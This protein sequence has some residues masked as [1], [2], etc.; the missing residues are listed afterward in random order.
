MLAEALIGPEWEQ[1]KGSLSQELW[2]ALTHQTWVA[3]AAPA[4]LL[5]PM[6]V[7]LSTSQ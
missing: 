3:T 1:R 6:D 4:G 7:L 5:L 2:R